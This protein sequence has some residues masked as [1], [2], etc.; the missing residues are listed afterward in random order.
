MY[1]VHS[2]Q[3]DCSVL[4]SL[5][6]ARTNC[7]KFARRFLHALRFSLDMVIRVPNTHTHIQIRRWQLRSRRGFYSSATPNVLTS[8][9]ILSF[10]THQLDRVKL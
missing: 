6:T 1:I 8:H 5:F 3:F 4:F 2:Q 7:V 10:G 9:H